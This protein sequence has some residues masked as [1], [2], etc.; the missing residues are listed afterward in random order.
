MYVYLSLNLWL[1]CTHCG[2]IEDNPHYPEL[3]NL[4]GDSNSSSD[5]Q[6]PDDVCVS[7]FKFALV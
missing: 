4:R 7:K 6:K 2:I 3:P 5:S 1:V